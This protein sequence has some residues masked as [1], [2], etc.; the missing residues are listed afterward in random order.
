[1]NLSGLLSNITRAE[2]LDARKHAKRLLRRGKPRA[3][4]ANRMMEKYPAADVLM[5][6]PVKPGH[7]LFTKEKL[8]GYRS[9]CHLI[10][11]LAE[12]SGNAALQG[13]LASITHEEMLL[14]VEEMLS[15]DKMD[16][17][18]WFR[19]CSQNYYAYVLGMWEEFL[20]ILNSGRNDQSIGFL[21]VVGGLLII[22]GNRD[23]AQTSNFNP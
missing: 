23:G 4:R 17:A 6:L 18:A 19:S 16:F 11:T 9:A 12:A 1:M 13:E 5:S 15:A 2:V 7:V 14:A 20:G 21:I 8:E 3:A 22:A 10:S